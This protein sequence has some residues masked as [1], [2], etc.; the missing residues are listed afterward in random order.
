VVEL[1]EVLRNGV[2]TK[3]NRLGAETKPAVWKNSVVEAREALET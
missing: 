2:E 3:F 1:R